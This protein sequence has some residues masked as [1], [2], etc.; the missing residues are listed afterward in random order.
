MKLALTILG[1]VYALAFTCD[2][3]DELAERESD[4]VGSDAPTTSAGA[5]S[6]VDFGFSPSAAPGRGEYWGDRR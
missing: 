2:P 4:D 1:R 3:D 6:Q 5:W